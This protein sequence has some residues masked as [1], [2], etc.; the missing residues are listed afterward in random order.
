MPNRLRRVRHPHAGLYFL[1]A[2]LMTTA[3]GHA[4]AL[5]GT[6]EW[7]VMRDSSTTNDQLNAN[8]SFWQNYVVGLSAALLDPRLVK[9]D[10]EVSFRTN[11]VTGRRS[12]QGDQEG[13]QGDIGFRLGA[14]LFPVGQFPLYVQ[15]SRVNSSASGDLGPSNP[16]R[17]GIALPA[18]VPL[19]QFQTRTDV[20][21]VGGRLTAERLPRLEVGLR[22]NSSLVTGASYVS[23]RDD[24]DMHAVVSKETTRMRQVLRFQRTAYRNRLTETFSQRLDNLDYDLGANLTHRTRVSA[25]AGRR[26]SDIHSVGPA[27]LVDPEIGAYVP[28]QAMG[29]TS[30]RYAQAGVSYDPASRL[31]L[32]LDAS[33]DRQ[34]DAAASTSGNLITGAAHVG[35]LRGLSLNIGATS[36]TR[37]Q[38][39]G[40]QPVTVFSRSGEAT[41]RY[42]V[43]PGWLS[44]SA[45]VTAGLGV[46]VSP[47]GRKGRSESWARELSIS[48]SI[49]WFGVGAGYE[50]A[51]SRD[52]I[53][54]Y[55][56]YE[57]EHIRASAQAQST[58]VA[59][60]TSVDQLRVSR[61]AGDTF[62][63]NL[64]RTWSESATYRLWRD[65]VA[66][67]SAGG[68]SNVYR[69]S[70]GRG[71][72]RSVFWGTGLQM[73]VAR[74]R[75]SGWVR[76][77]L[78]S[79]AATR[80][81][82]RNVSAA[83]RLEYR[84]RAIGAALEYRHN[85]SAMQYAEM[86]SP[87]RFRGH[88]LRFTLSRRFEVGL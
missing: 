30:T 86:E 26:T 21:E 78:V 60:S 77:E 16:I 19:P 52:G 64:Q 37:G 35:V 65:S 85:D 24:D 79:A 22:R 73:T 49:R 61:G 47:E 70:L 48:S 88:Q 67:L 33:V 76:R 62:V 72:D 39:I 57:S 59:L 53:L 7:T 15:A 32:R 31:G 36:G 1:A 74:L 58:R 12:N 63:A 66:T 69:N 14:S 27:P 9:Y 42:L 38:R 11:A 17:S 10:A 84:L 45:G 71:R 20:L 43:G 75:V 41:L 40:N 54:D 3:I 87:D 50:Q 81:S 2:T 8:S 23:S 34:G 80:F 18:D 56:N 51:T 6:A 13:H 44:T 29:R 68:F 5:S 4:Q 82:Q 83:A 55:G 25:H 28:P 46:N